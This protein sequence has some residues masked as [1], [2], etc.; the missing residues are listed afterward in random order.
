M[1]GSTEKMVR[2][3][4]DHLVAR[5]IH[6]KPYNLV[7]TDPGEI[8]MELVS[9]A[10]IV[11]AAS[12]VLVG[13]HPAA[14]NAAYLV[15]ALRPKTRFLSII[16]S[17]GW[18]SRIVETLSGMIPNLKV[19]MLPTVIVKGY[20]NAEALKA[21]EDLADEILKKHKEANLIS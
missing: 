9:A 16:G 17:F 10:T 13:P 3:L 6:V 15:N 20:P 14:V 18:G 12:T 2:H 8:A 4:T 7:V 5:G 21:I 1:H 11:I 19:E